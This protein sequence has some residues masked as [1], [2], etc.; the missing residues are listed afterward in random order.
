MSTRNDSSPNVKYIRVG[1]FHLHASR[2]WWQLL[3]VLA[4]ADNALMNEVLHEGGGRLKHPLLPARLVRLLR[5]FRC[6]LSGMVC[7]YKH[8]PDDVLTLPAEG[9]VAF[10]SNSGAIK[11]F[12]TSG[13]RIHTFLPP[14]ELKVYLDKAQLVSGAPFAPLLHV[15]DA[16]REFVTEEL[17][18]GSHPR[19]EQEI[20]FTRVYLPLLYQLAVAQRPK[21]VP[22]QRYVRKLVEG[23]TGPRSLFCRLEPE[24]QRL[25]TSLLATLS[26]RLK[27]ADMPLPL[28]LSHGD[29]FSKNVVVQNGVTRAIDWTR[30][31]YR[32]PLFDLYFLYVHHHSRWTKLETL[33]ARIHD[34]IDAF[35]AA[36]AEKPEVSGTL[37]P[38]LTQDPKYRWLFYLECIYMKLVTCDRDAQTCLEAHEHDLKRYEAFEAYLRSV[39]KDALPPLSPD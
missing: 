32:S 4:S 27:S 6:T 33:E 14:D 36:V 13:G 31:D 8:A 38:F 37:A 21:T 3:G 11:V 16:D 30:A 10:V 15:N 7:R 25:A 2:P 9:M 1:K 29:L 5:A 17:I 35:A 24:K 22:I 12:D 28:V 20:D 39:G 23:I 19:R 18:P 34:A 26:N